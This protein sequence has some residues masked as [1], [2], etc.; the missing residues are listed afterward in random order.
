MFQTTKQ[1]WWCEQFGHLHTKKSSKTPF[2]LDLDWPWN[3][4]DGGPPGVSGHPVA[5]HTPPKTAKSFQPPCQRSSLI[6]C[7]L[8]ACSTLWQLNIA[9]EN[10]WQWPFI[11]AFPIRNSDCPNHL[12]KLRFFTYLNLKAIKGDD[13]NL[14]MILVRE[15]SEVVVIFPEPWANM[16]VP[17]AM[18]LCFNKIGRTNCSKVMK[19]V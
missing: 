13:F 15:N 14:T 6:S 5:G 4:L 12:G 17:V 9:I 10:D 18:L 2:C 8:M 7:W 3:A 16:V 19:W 11:V 1:F